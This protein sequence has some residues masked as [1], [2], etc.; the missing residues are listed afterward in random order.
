MMRNNMVLLLLIAA[1]APAF[2]GRMLLAEVDAKAD[3]LTCMS[4]VVKVSPA[5]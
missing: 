2:A 3:T 4:T 5:G 1:A